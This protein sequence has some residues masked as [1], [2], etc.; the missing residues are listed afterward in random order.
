MNQPLEPIVD[1]HHHI[2]RVAETPWLNGPPVARIFGDYGPLRRDYGIDEYLGAALPAGVTKSVFVQVNVAAGRE[3]AE[4]A[5]VQAVADRCGFP[6]AITAYADLAAPGIAGVLDAELASGKV[7]AIRQQLH[8]HANPLY[9]YAATAN[10]TEQAAWRQGL[11]E[12]AKRGLLFELQ[13]FPAQMPAAA[14]LVRSFADV[15]FVLLHAGMLEDRS[16]EGWARWRAGMRALALCPNVMV[17]I[18]GLGTFEHACST[19][20]WRP[21]VE[22]TIDLFGPTRCLFGS[23]FPIESL[24]TTYAEVVAAVR[25]SLL[26]YGKDER[27]AVLHDTAM[28]LYRLA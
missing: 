12:V 22:E 7:R 19:A 28:R 6:Q 13:I 18:S 11:R 20:L 16:E 4:V 27:R 9:R 23:N 14:H 10:L 24:W 2:W 3:V 26:R 5:W 21:V 25:Q 1:A 8:W 17:K 15:T